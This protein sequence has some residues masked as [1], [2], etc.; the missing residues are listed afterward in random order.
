[1]TATGTQATLA[2]YPSAQAAP[3]CQSHSFDL[4]SYK[5][6]TVTISFTG[7]PSWIPRSGQAKASFVLDNVSLDCR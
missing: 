7:R 5:G 4:S 2:R 3:G 1:M 6:Q